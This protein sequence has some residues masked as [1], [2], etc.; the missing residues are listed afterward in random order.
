MTDAQAER[1]IREFLDALVRGDLAGAEEACKS[2]SVMAGEIAF[3]G[4]VG[5]YGLAGLRRTRDGHGVIFWVEVL[6]DDGARS[7]YEATV[8]PRIVVTSACYVTQFRK[9]DLTYPQPPPSP[10]GEGGGTR[11]AAP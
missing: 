6:G 10:A 7:R 4:R 5:S 1:C 8:E 2:G 9:T 3:P 11:R